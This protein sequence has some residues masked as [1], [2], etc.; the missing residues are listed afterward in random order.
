[1]RRCLADS[2]AQGLREKGASESTARA[3]DTMSLRFHVGMKTR[4]DPG[5]GLSFLVLIKNSSDPTSEGALFNA[6]DELLE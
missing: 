6:A 3:R 2:S 5:R 1:M 4:R